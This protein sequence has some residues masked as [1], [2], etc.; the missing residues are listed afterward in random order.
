M[1]VPAGPDSTPETGERDA[2]RSSR[3]ALYQQEVDL[4]AI[5]VGIS[6]YQHEPWN[7]KYADRDAEELLRLIDSPVGGKYKEKHILTFVNEQATLPK[8]QGA[9]RSFLQKPGRDDLVLLYFACHGTPDPNRPGNIYLLT[10]DTDPENI[11]ATALPMREI[12][13]PFQDGT[14]LAE[15]V[16]ILADT[17]HSAAIAG[18]LG[19]GVTDRADQVNRS[20][21]SLSK[22]HGGI[23]L[24]TSAE[25]DESSKEGAEWGG[26]HGVFTHFLLEGM[27]GAADGYP[28]NKRKKNGTVEIGELFEYVRDNV[29]DKTSNDQH[30]AIGTESFDRDLPIAWTGGVQA[31]QHC[32]LGRRLY[33]L[34]WL[35]DDQGR[36]RS[37]MRHFDEAL[38]LSPEPLLDAYLGRGQARYALGQ[39]REAVGDLETAGRLDA[40]QSEASLYLGLAHAKQDEREPAAAALKAFAESH[41]GDTRTPWLQKLSAEM[42]CPATGIKR[43]LLI[44]IGQYADPSLNLKGPPND[45]R[46]IRGILVERFGFAEENI[47]E[48]LDTNA[49]RQGILA[50]LEELKSK[51]QPNDTVVVYYTGHSMQGRSPEYLMP[52]EV[53]LDSTSLI[54]NS[55][56]AENLHEL[57]NAIPARRKTVILDTHSTERFVELVRKEAN[58]TL[59]LAASPDTTAYEHV[60]TVG[61][62]QVP[63]GLYT[64]A[65]ATQLEKTPAESTQAQLADAVAKAVQQIN[66]QQR[67]QFFGRTDRP[68]FGGE[69]ETDSLVPFDFSQCQNF[70]AFSWQELRDRYTVLRHDLGDLPFPE[71]HYRF[72]CAFLE[73]KACAMALEA[74]Q[75]A[76]KQ[77]ATPYAEACL[78]VGI[79]QLGLQRYADAQQILLQYLE[80]VPDAQGDLAEP[81]QLLDRLQKD[82]RYAVLV[83]IDLYKHPKVPLAELYRGDVS[84]AGAVN[85]A[86]ALKRALVEQ[87][88]FAETDVKLLINKE[89]TV[90]AITA[91]FTDLASQ[92]REAPALFY[93]AGAGSLSRDYAPVIMGVDEEGRAAP[94]DLQALAQIVAGSSSN[95]VTILDAGWTRGAKL[96]W[97]APWGSRYF[98]S[99]A[100]GLARGLGERRADEPE[101]GL[102]AA[103]QWKSPEWIEAHTRIG[104]SLQP[105]ALG[106]MSIYQVSIQATFGAG[107]PDGTDA[108]VESEFPALDKSRK[109]RVHGALT[110][111]LVTCL[112]DK[113]LKE[114][115]TYSALARSLQSKLEWLQPYFVGD[116][117]DLDERIFS[118]A[119]L[120]ERIRALIRQRI[121]QRPIQETIS[122]LKETIQRQDGIDPASHLDMG[123]A[124]AAIGDFKHSLRELEKA[125]DQSPDQYCPEAYYHRGRVHYEANDNLDQAVSDLKQAKLGEPDNPRIHYY[126]G[127]AIRARVARENEALRD[128]QEALKTYLESG[129]PLGRRDEVQQ[130]LNSG[131]RIGTGSGGPAPYPST[132]TGT[133]TGGPAPYPDMETTMSDPGLVGYL[134]TGTEQSD[135]KP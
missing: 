104:Q 134:G 45:R 6:R 69:A 21:Q 78:Q 16:I 96:P 129:A 24:L 49:T 117:L 43:A 14:L 51:A 88:G 38:R 9:L 114:G 13:Q 132:G 71:L 2:R 47:R 44:G 8:I 119:V 74:L 1:T 124:Y 31:Q 91:A 111:A 115:L 102:I 118:N 4:W 113:E 68:L 48:L 64:Y 109:R 77:C 62:K 12:N 61:R 28:P 55:I 66:P 17:C 11:A 92:A 106:R 65:L 23:A 107:R 89:A 120:E 110:H 29:R 97:G 20:L 3:T 122:A 72:G 112:Q 84:L 54:N 126:F 46:L 85:D 50:A 53:G 22:A 58:Y 121:I 125:I 130:F 60:A 79:A 35:L 59:F 76:R 94:L 57:L 42:A 95:L 131:L 133:G 52:H 82:H 30:P 135:T 18:R 36:T 75:T 73:K 81:L 40:G 34:G 87:C 98:E 90:R 127:Q 41:P 56:S 5:I 33:E 26:G 67:P 63:Y 32:Q 15:R 70:A 128:A 105:L 123:V 19:R 10:Y 7:L 100:L 103:P 116:Q 39:Y 83:G 99:A 27:G 37:A 25:K 101:P 86:T 108:V 93:F 80:A